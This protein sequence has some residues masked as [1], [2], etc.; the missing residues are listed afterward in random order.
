MK[1][2]IVTISLLLLLICNFLFASEFKIPIVDNENSWAFIPMNKATGNLNIDD[3]TMKVFFDFSKGDYSSHVA[4]HRNIEKTDSTPKA[5]GFKIYKTTY[6][7]LG[8]RVSDDTGETFQKMVDVPSNNQWIN[9]EVKYNSFGGFWGGDENGI[10]NGSATGIGFALEKGGTSENIGEVFIKDIYI[11][12]EDN[13]KVDPFIEYELD[14]FQSDK[15]RSVI[16]GYGQ[17]DFSAKNVNISLPTKDSYAGIGG[18]I[19]IFGEPKVLKLKIK[20]PT[21]GL[22]LNVK[23]GSH[24]VEF[25]RNFFNLPKGEQIV[26]I[27]VSKGMEHWEYNNPQFTGALPGTLRVLE[28]RFLSETPFYGNVELDNLYCETMLTADRLITLAPKAEIKEN[29]AI[30]KIEAL[31][32]LPEDVNTNLILTISDFEGNILTTIKQPVFI[33]S[34]GGTINKTFSY[35]LGNKS[36]LE[37]KVSI[38]YN[39]ISYGNQTICVVKDIESKINVGK[40]SDSIFGMGAYFY[41]YGN[42][43]NDYEDMRK[44]AGL[45]EK[46][47]IKWSRE[48]FSWANIEKSSG[49]FDWDFYDKL[50][51]IAEEHNISV[52]GL[53]CYWNT[54]VPA[55]TEEGRQAYY[56]FVRKTVTRYK[57]RIKHWEIWNEPNIFFFPGPKENYVKMLIESYKIIKEIDPSAQVLGCSTSGIDTSFINFCIDNGAIFDILT[58]HPY[59]G[60]LDDEGFRKEL[61]DITEVT[62]KIDGEIKPVWITEMGW[63]TQLYTGTTER[64]QAS[65]IARAYIDT[66]TV[67]SV[68]NISWYDF[69]NDGDNKYYNEH[70]FGTL[71]HNYS[72]KPSYVAVAKVIENLE[73]AKFIREIDFGTNIVCFEYLK[74]NQKLTVL[75]SKKSGLFKADF[76]ENI[77]EII[78]LIGEK[79]SFIQTE[80]ESIL[81]DLKENTPVFVFG[82]FAFLNEIEFKFPDSFNGGS[83][84]DLSDIFKNDKLKIKIGKLPVSWKL[85]GNKITIPR[86]NTIYSETIPVSFE[87]K[88]KKI[89]VNYLVKI[90]PDLLRF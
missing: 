35:P 57:D 90:L 3:N 7:R 81:F 33:K 6:H 34:K 68:Q 36:F 54:W 47:G 64:E 29:Q 30:F 37:G 18:D 15:F 70:N 2:F 5:I 87:S 16:F 86:V 78:N 10:F 88:G 53:L 43:T 1:N 63:S 48:E 89:T 41:R 59:R 27:P 4:F 52:Y 82:T 23:L 32:L 14:D 9:I 79:I 46:I 72:P 24:F 75:W 26:E 56:N 58:I 55:D 45:A 12:Y 73:N 40:N 60:A 25:Y 66:T 13:S 20:T 85:S 22:R 51:S 11:V 39:G 77:P 42:P 69:R 21:E 71:K 76:K 49:N 50:V 67:P 38:D 61:K 44:I 62:K 17:S 83:I 8:I 74:N 19:E 65:L 28:L 80:K 31:N 84:V